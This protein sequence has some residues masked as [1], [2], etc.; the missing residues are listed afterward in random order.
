MQWLCD[1]YRNWSNLIS[2]CI[3]CNLQCLQHPAMVS[4]NNLFFHVDHIFLCGT[5]WCRDCHL[6]QASLGA[7]QPRSMSLWCSTAIYSLWSVQLSRFVSLR[8]L[9]RLFECPLA[10]V[11]ILDWC[12]QRVWVLELVYFIHKWMGTLW[13]S[14]VVIIAG[15]SFAILCAVIFSRRNC[16]HAI[17][18]LPYHILSPQVFWEV[19]KV[20]LGCFW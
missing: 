15:S 18:H 3:D 8:L 12:V 10:L 5:W 2:R 14:I 17:C 20:H 19:N 13:L 6:Q 7:W 16:R 1:M 11:C 4:G 9:L